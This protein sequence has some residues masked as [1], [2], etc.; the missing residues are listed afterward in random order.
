[1]LAVALEFSLFLRFRVFAVIATVMLIR[2]HHALTLRVPAFL[3]RTLAH[4]PVSFMQQNCSLTEAPTL[5]AVCKEMGSLRV[6]AELSE[7]IKSGAPPRGAP[8]TDNLR[9]QR[10]GK[11]H[12]IHY[13]HNPIGL[14]NVS[15]GHGRG[16]AFRVG[17]NH[18]LT[19]Q[20]GS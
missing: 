9:M 18:V 16:A 11:Q 3:V 5:S 17:N 8:V 12:R 4:I 10:L 1:M 13:M 2:S 19:I 6:Q 20:R 7:Q 15:D 14:V